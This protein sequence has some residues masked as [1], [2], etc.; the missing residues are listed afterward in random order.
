[1][2]EPRAVPPAELYSTLE[3]AS[4]AVMAEARTLMAVAANMEEGGSDP[5]A[6]LAALVLVA[7]N[8]AE[9]MGVDDAVFTAGLPAMW[10]AGRQLAAQA[11]ALQSQQH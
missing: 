7:G 10:R 4:A 6:V 1:M 11:A 5:A 9:R 3:A 2:K 8:M